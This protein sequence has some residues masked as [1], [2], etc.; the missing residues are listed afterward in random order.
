M[1]ED[2]HTPVLL[3][4][5]LMALAIKPDGHYLDATFG[6][7]G[8]SRGILRALGPRGSLLAIDRDPAAVAAGR[9]L[10]QEDRRFRMEAGSFSRL[11][12]LAKRHGLSGRVHG[13]LL[14][15]G[16]S[17]PQL[18]G[19]DRG[20]SFIQ[21]G[22]LDMRM[23]PGAGESAASWLNRVAEAEIA[24]VLSEYGEERFAR[25]IARAVVYARGDAP[26]TTTGQLA[27]IIERASPSREPGK[28]PATRSFQAI[29]I[30][31]NQELEELRACLTRVT[32]LLAPGGRLVAI[33]FHSLEDRIVKRFLRDQARGD[34]FPVDLPVTREQLRPRL[35]L[36]GKARRPSPTEVAANPRARSA[37]MRVAEKLA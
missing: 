11:A 17:S 8:H 23:D 32:G 19:A 7:G 29:R 3:E 1:A 30:Y 27:K 2:A 4:E 28:H 22:P 10:E 33:S 37:V 20:F 16:V 14:D 35:R 18:E 12:E 31:I 36:L 21:D 9:R 25:R 5:A 24:R 6:R 26:I 15:L 34:R 13:V